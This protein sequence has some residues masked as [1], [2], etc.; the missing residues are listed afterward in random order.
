MAKEI[1]QEIGVAKEEIADK[2]QL[3]IRGKNALMNS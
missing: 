3:E 2:Y 1:Q